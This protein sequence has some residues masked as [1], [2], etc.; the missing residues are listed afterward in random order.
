MAITRA[1]TAQKNE[2]W[3]ESVRFC[4]RRVS[5]GM[6]VLKIV[7]ISAV[8]GSDKHFGLLCAEAKCCYLLT[9][10]LQK[11]CANINAT[12]GLGHVALSA[13]PKQSDTFQVRRTSDVKLH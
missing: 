9:E 3:Q 6:N 12:C 2:A 10:L 13:M 7:A 8:M 5:Q 1:W 4:Q 11:P